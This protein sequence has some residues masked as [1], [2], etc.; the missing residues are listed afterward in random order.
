MKFEQAK[1]IWTNRKKWEKLTEK[2]KKLV[3]YILEY[4]HNDFFHNS[5]K[6]VSDDKYEECKSEWKKYRDVEKLEK[7]C[8]IY[9]SRSHYN[10]KKETIAE[11]LEKYISK[12]YEKFFPHPLKICRL[13]NVSISLSHKYSTE[14][15]YGYKYKCDQF[16]LLLL[17]P[18]TRYKITIIDNITTILIG[19]PQKIG[20]CET[21]KQAYIAKKLNQ[22]LVDHLEPCV[23]MIAGDFAAHE[24][25]VEKCAKTIKRKIA[26]Q[27][28]KAEKFT[29]LQSGIITAETYQKLTGACT[30]G[31]NAWLAD[32]NLTRADK[33][34][35]AEFWEKFKSESFFGKEK[36]R[37]YFGF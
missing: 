13:E 16:F 22:Y 37:K 32:H 10:P 19:E 9:N 12:K 15:K 24:E 17:P 27:K 18:K 20:N 30:A 7:A 21:W 36:F 29:E 23:V 5:L 25:T 6:R 3:V 26:A 35:A 2:E 14:Y 11:R 4:Y 28:R 1:K 31:T 8:K 34:T 33:M